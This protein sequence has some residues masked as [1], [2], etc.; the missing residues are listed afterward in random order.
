MVSLI[1]A[2]YATASANEKAP[3]FNTECRDLGSNDQCNNGDNDYCAQRALVSQVTS[4]GRFCRQC[5]PLIVPNSK[6]SIEYPKCDEDGAEPFLTYERETALQEHIL[7]SGYRCCKIGA[8]ES[9]SNALKVVPGGAKDSYEAMYL[10]PMIRRSF[11]LYAQDVMYKTYA[12]GEWVGIVKLPKS[13]GKSKLTAKSK[14]MAKEISLLS[15]TDVKSIPG[16]ARL[17]ATRSY[18]GGDMQCPVTER[19]DGNVREL[20]GASLLRP[21]KQP[22]KKRPQK[23]P[24]KKIRKSKVSKRFLPSKV[25]SS[26][27]VLENDDEVLENDDDTEE[28]SPEQAFAERDTCA[29]ALMLMHDVLETL[30]RLHEIGIVHADLSLDNIAVKPVKPVAEDDASFFKLVNFAEAFQLANLESEH[31]H[32]PKLGFPERGFRGTLVP[33]WRGAGHHGNV[34]GTWN[35]MSDDVEVLLQITALM[36]W[37]TQFVA[38]DMRYRGPE[39]DLS[40]KQK[41]RFDLLVLGMGRLSVKE[42]TLPSFGRKDKQRFLEFFLKNRRGKK[43][44]G[45]E[46]QNW[47]HNIPAH[48]I[49]GKVFKP[50]CLSTMAEFY[51]DGLD[52]DGKYR[53]ELDVI[54][55][56]GFLTYR[57]PK[58]KEEALKKLLEVEK[59]ILEKVR[60]AFSEVKY[61]E[62]RVESYGPLKDLTF[63]QKQDLWDSATKKPDVAQGGAAANTENDPPADINIMDAPIVDTGLAVPMST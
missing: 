17:V 27:E 37:P 43:E 1:L 22:T 32:L 30:H 54:K 60:I 7:M 62:A 14:L 4:R 38:E 31:R 19:L 21:Q 56:K 40:E 44:E 5:G 9:T 48:T 39:V 50:L 35:K 8:P 58:V 36:I 34:H 33:R 26:Y 29:A 20:H 10:G 24:T 12:G 13:S 16:V 41:R 28:A 23:Q 52:Q 57:L 42:E 18:L 11:L 63:A 2:A 25:L 53:D 45:K 55:M 46:F 3:Q 6:R 51:R 15:L 49:C 61:V 47:C 59:T